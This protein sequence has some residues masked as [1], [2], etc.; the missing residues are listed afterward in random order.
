VN[1]QSAVPQSK[2]ANIERLRGLAALA[3][4]VCHIAG[5]FYGFTRSSPGPEKLYAWIGQAGVAV[6]FVISGF[7]IRLPEAR[8]LAQGGPIRL[9]VREYLAR[10]FL[11]IAPPYWI[12]LVASIAAGALART[13]LVDGA[14]G[15]MDILAH[16]FLVHSL[17]ASTFNGTN[18]VFWTIGLEAHFYLAYLLFANRPARVWTAAALLVLGL[19][20]FGLASSLI[21]ATSPWRI[22]AQTVFLTSFWQWYL[23]ALIADWWVKAPR[24]APAAPLWLARILAVMAT[25]LLGLIDPRVGGLHL[26]GWILPFGATAVVTLFVVRPSVTRPD[27]PM[28]KSINWLGQASYSLYLFH[29][30]ALS[31]AVYAMAGRPAWAGAT[32]CMALALLLAAASYGLVEKPLLRWRAKLRRAEV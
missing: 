22:V 21:A 13:E 3:V 25:L 10:R 19:G 16:L 26:N 14:R 29:P 30:V 20:V 4:V 23:G 32:I 7:C 5:H 6:F 28:L 12:A 27:S 9:D 1:T 17:W 11:R 24:T 8:A 2:I 31:L 18:A 15:P